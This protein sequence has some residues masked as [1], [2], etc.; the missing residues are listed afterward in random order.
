MD[1]KDSI[2][3]TVYGY[4]WFMDQKGNFIDPGYKLESRLLPRLNTV[5]AIEEANE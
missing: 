2:S 1:S 4:S 5:E 3:V